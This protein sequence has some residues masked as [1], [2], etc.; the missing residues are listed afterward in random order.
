MK[1]LDSIYTLLIKWCSIVLLVLLPV[2]PVMIAAGVLIVLDMITGMLASRKQGERITS[3]G[4]K[5]T[6]GKMFLYQS[7]I[8]VG[9]LMEHYLLEGIPVVKV[10]AGIIALTE[11]KSFFENVHRITGIDFWSEALA[12][13]QSA[14]VKQIPDEVIQLPI[15]APKKKSK[16]RKKKKK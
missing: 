13:I 1:Y 15:E 12:K 8:V 9:F 5:K 14:T 4:L 16:K 2:R 7:S 10:I 11:G 6:V 3:S